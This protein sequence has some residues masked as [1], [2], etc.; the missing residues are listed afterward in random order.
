MAGVM[1]ART[2]RVSATSPGIVKRKIKKGGAKAKTKAAQKGAPLFRDM[3]LVWGELPGGL[4]PA[5]VSSPDWQTIDIE[6]PTFGPEPTSPHAAILNEP[7]DVA[8]C[9]G[10][11]ATE[12][13]G[14][15]PLFDS[16]GYSDLDHDSSAD[17]KD[18]L[19]SAA[20]GEHD[21]GTEIEWWGSMEPLVL[22]TCVAPGAA[23]DGV[24]TVSLA[25]S[26]H[27][28]E[29][30]ARSS[31]VQLRAAVREAFGLSE[32]TAFVLRDPDG[33][34]VPVNTNLF[35][36]PFQLEVIEA[37]VNPTTTARVPAAIQPAPSGGYLPPLE[38]VQEPPKGSC[39]WLTVKVTKA[40]V[41]K[42][43]AHTFTIEVAAAHG[44]PEEQQRW[45]EGAQVRL[46]NPALEEVTHLLHSGS[47]TVRRNATGRLTA[48]WADVAI[49]EVSSTH[50]AGVV[51]VNLRGANAI[52][53][54]RCA[55]GW[56]H[57]C[58]SSPG[59]ADLWLRSGSV[60]D[61]EELG[62]IIVKHKRCYATG[63]WVE[64]H[65]G[66]YADHSLC[67]PSHIGPDG[68]RLCRNACC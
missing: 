3:G 30:S 58:V 48:C 1:S 42:P 59:A 46:F 41:P 9:G 68:V 36:G 50:S 13:N 53:G 29:F 32:G 19:E 65:L 64:K 7:L 25:G 20:Y 12:R 11:H 45:L 49:T 26:E 33:C 67:R 28:I 34:V 52:K 18:A 4:A 54:G 2:N 6:L 47:K 37:M 10:G 60:Q 27:D 57:L 16:P 14:Y 51:G 43:L 5:P 22:S 62:K 17:M 40:G 31:S 38:F 44:K 56:F 63:R 24:I 23:T 61:P 8:Y 39:E 66:P 55:Q 35:A 15:S 21:V